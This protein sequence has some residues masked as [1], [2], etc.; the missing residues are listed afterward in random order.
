M[1]RRRTCALSNVPREQ[2]PNR[3]SLPRRQDRL[4]STTPAPVPAPVAAS[5]RPE[6]PPTPPSPPRPAKPRKPPREIDW[7]MFLGAR[8]LAL[9]GGIVT[10]LGIVF[11]FILAANRGW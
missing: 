7:S 11:F 10:I 1:R 4:A 3:L 5:I 2:A 9:A 8:G 6:P